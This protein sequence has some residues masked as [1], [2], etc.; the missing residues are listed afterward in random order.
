MD[1]LIDSFDEFDMWLKQYHLEKRVYINNY[2]DERMR[3]LYKNKLD[4][5][6]AGLIMYVWR[7]SDFKKLRHGKKLSHFAL[8][9]AL[10]EDYWAGVPFSY[11]EDSSKRVIATVLAYLKMA[12]LAQTT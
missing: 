3:G 12:K 1:V 2:A 4:R 11:A 9:Q 10:N 6:R 8:N 5:I 7:I